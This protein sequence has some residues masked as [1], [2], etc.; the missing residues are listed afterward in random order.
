MHPLDAQRYDLSQ[1]LS[2]ARGEDDV[3]DAGSARSGDPPVAQD[4]SSI[5]TPRSPLL[6][7]ARTALRLLPLHSHSH[8]CDAL[9]V[10][11]P[12]SPLLSTKSPSCNDF[13][14]DTLIPD[15]LNQHSITLPVPSEDARQIPEKL[16]PPLVA[17]SPKVAHPFVPPSRPLFHQGDDSESS[18]SRPRSISPMSPPLSPSR[19]MSPRFWRSACPTPLG[20]HKRPSSPPYH[21]SDGLASDRWGPMSCPTSPLLRSSNPP[22]PPPSPSAY[23]TSPTVSR[24][25]RA[26]SS[27]SSGISLRPSCPMNPTS[28]PTSPVLQALSFDNWLPARDPTA[29]IDVMEIA[30]TKHICVCIEGAE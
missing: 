8:K 12:L 13:T 1:R 21:R 17:P 10:P 11:L 3:P 9:S 30:V 24:K 23:Q 22:P 26:L 16:F 14:E 27:T 7:A 6:R 5:E 19:P 20:W 4:V 2:P 18:V 25:L 29:R 28:W 15:G